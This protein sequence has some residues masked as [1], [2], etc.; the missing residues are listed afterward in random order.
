MHVQ[1]PMQREPTHWTSGYGWMLSGL[2][3]Q[4]HFRLQPLKNTVVLRPGPSSVD[5][6]WISSIRPDIDFSF[7]IEGSIFQL[8]TSNTDS[9]NDVLE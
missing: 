2:W 7:C 6:R 4:A 8:F 1:H 5:I 3:H 9:H